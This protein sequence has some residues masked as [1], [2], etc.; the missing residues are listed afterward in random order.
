M[1]KYR[2]EVTGEWRRVHSEE[3]HALYIS[4]NIISCG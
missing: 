4:P 1:K 3:L 2:E